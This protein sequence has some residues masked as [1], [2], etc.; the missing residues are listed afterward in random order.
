MRLPPG[1][2]R[3][4]VAGNSRE[5][6]KDQLGFL[7]EAARTYGD[8]VSLTFFHVPVYLLNNP[9]HIERVFGSRNFS[10]PKSLRLPLQRRIFGNGLLASDGEVWLRERRLM[11]PAF[12]RD[13]LAMYAEVMNGCTEKMLADWDAEAVRDVYDEM[14]AL[15]LT[16]AAG[17]LFNAELGRDGAMVREISNTVTKVFAAQGRPLWI[18]DNFLPT[19]NNL[20]FRRAIKQLDTI[21]YS[22][23]SGHRKGEISDDLVTM[24]LSAVDEDGTC[25]SRQQLRDELATLFFA[26]HEAAALV[27]TW[28]CYLLARYPEKQAVLA[29]EFRE[30]LQERVVPGVADLTSLPYTRMV[31]K[32]ATRLYPPNR[33]VGRE[34]LNDCEIG[35]YHVPAGTQLLMSQW[36]VHRD[37]RYFES[38]EKFHPE[39]WTPE[40]V[41]QLP[42]YAYFP[43]GGGPRVCIGQDFAIMEATLVIATILRRFKLE[44]IEDQVVEPQPVVLLR[45][46]TRIMIRATVR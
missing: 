32:E 13:R 23:I 25:M 9:E 2:K 4:L 45:P 16:I 7:S 8:V 19:P 40:F 14:R 44:L 37:S 21:I 15:A 31:I 43:F 5:F 39:R 1:P 26:S 20:R 12:H 10:K 17:C 6:Y 11:Q 42:K 18:L 33:S 38:P 36:V 27:L 46:K 30:H 3:Q 22:L 28:T 34:A 24:L 41:A 35:D 29:A